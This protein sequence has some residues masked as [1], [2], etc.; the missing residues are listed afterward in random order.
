MEPEMDTEG[1]RQT[2]FS[3]VGSEVGL[4][5]DELN[6][7]MRRN[8]TNSV[9][10]QPMEWIE[11]H[12]RRASARYHTVD[13]TSKLKHQRHRPSTLSSRPWSQAVSPTPAHSKP[14]SIRY[15]KTNPCDLSYLA[16]FK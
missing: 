10:V 8:T 12:G 14:A 15:S 5:L 6:W 9:P 11:E 1:E 2:D 13:G 4:S 3:P 16:S 7:R